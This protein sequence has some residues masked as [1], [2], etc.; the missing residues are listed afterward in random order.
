VRVPDA[1]AAHVGDLSR[2]LGVPMNAFYVLGAGLLAARLAPG[3]ATKRDR[4]A[5]L[6]FL[7]KELTGILAEARKEG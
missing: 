1:L 7:E 4:K 5:A 3:A 2:K 6:D